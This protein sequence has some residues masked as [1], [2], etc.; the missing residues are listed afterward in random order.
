M[1]NWQHCFLCYKLHP[2]PFHPQHDIV[3]CQDI[4]SCCCFCSK[5]F[6]WF[7]DSAAAVGHLIAILPRQINK[8]K[9]WPW[10]WPLHV[11]SFPPVEFAPRSHNS[12][13]EN[14]LLLSSLCYTGWVNGHN[15]CFTLIFVSFLCFTFLA[16]HLLASYFLKLFRNCL[17]TSL[18]G[19]IEFSVVK[20]RIIYNK[21]KACTFV[22]CKQFWEVSS[23]EFKMITCILR[24]SKIVVS[25]QMYSQVNRQTNLANRSSANKKSRAYT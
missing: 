3:A 12:H 10:P 16:V 15:Q 18:Y 13:Q 24:S 11:T 22:S 21:S 5:L 25:N 1:R 19:K 2:P 4:F 14:T 23:A 20:S 17:G 7:T 9:K 6:Y 8:C